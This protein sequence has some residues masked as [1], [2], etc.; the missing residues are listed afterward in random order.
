MEGTQSSN[1]FPTE[2]SWPNTDLAVKSLNLGGGDLSES[3]GRI[4]G[5][6]D[7][8]RASGTDITAASDYTGQS[9]IIFE[10]QTFATDANY[11]LVLVKQTDGSWD[12]FTDGTG[13]GGTDVMIAPEEI[14]VTNTF[15]N[16]ELSV[17]IASGRIFGNV[18][19]PGLSISSDNQFGYNSIAVIIMEYGAVTNP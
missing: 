17:N 9:F 11:D 8:L 12:G 6:I 18:S 3:L 16:A 1:N 10:S 14:Q 2:I 7:N 5:R 19:I 13:A 4:S 15:N